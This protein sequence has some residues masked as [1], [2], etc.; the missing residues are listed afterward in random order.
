[1]FASQ[2]TCGEIITESAIGSRA[3]GLGQ[4][5]TVSFSDILS[6]IKN[7]ANLYYSKKINSSF[8]Y[9]E[10]IKDTKN[11]SIGF[12]IPTKSIGTFGLSYFNFTVENFLE[13]DFSHE[14]MESFSFSQKEYVLSYGNQIFDRILFG[15]NAKW[16]TKS[17]PGLST[18]D[19]QF[20]YTSLDIS[21]ASFPNFTNTLLKNM[22]FGIVLK[23]FIQ[24]N[25]N[26]EYI[27]KAIFL[28]AENGYKM[29]NHSF[30]FIV[31]YT[32]LENL[33]NEYQTRIHLGMEYGYDFVFLRV[34]YN[35]DV[36]SFGTGLRYGYFTLNYGYGYFKNIYFMK[37]SIHNFSLNIEI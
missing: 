32:S 17:W 25:D 10:P 3:F 15:F 16:I 5:A 13:R 18:A 31:N 4:S 35:E 9:S 14:Q 29:S 22:G 37:R 30:F 26:N 27:P 28:L 11:Y 7:P 33:K 1:M 20:D 21:I 36:L 6:S 2:L 8:Y 19:L 34:G 12:T 23:N 24:A